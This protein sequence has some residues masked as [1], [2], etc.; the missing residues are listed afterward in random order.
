MDN[1]GLLELRFHTGQKLSSIFWSEK[2]II[3]VGMCGCR[4]IIV[5]M[6]SGSEGLVPWAIAEFDGDVVSKYNLLRV[7]GVTLWERIK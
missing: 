6:E 5:V 2:Q 3:Q 1:E 7:K 4:S